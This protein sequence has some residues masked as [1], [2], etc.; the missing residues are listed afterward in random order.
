MKTIVA[1]TSALLILSVTA[2]P[3]VRLP[4]TEEDKLMW[5]LIPTL[6]Y[7]FL[8]ESCKYVIFGDTSTGKYYMTVKGKMDNNKG[9]AIEIDDI[10]RVAR[11]FFWQDVSYGFE[12]IDGFVVYYRK[13]RK[14]FSYKSLLMRKGDYAIGD[15]NVDLTKYESN[16]QWSCGHRPDPS[17]APLWDEFVCTKEI[18]GDANFETGEVRYMPEVIMN[19]VGYHYNGNEEGKAYYEIGGQVGL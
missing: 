6:P 16:R 19:A 4:I 10:N 1:L 5:R 11:G 17:A 18:I 8:E 12:S 9:E 13:D 2:G 15:E 7:V 3:G 14:R